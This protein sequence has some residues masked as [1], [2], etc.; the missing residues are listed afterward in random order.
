[1][2]LWQKMFI[3]FWEMVFLEF[4]HFYWKRRTFQLNWIMKW[5][6]VLHAELNLI[7]WEKD[8]FYTFYNPQ[9]FQQT[10]SPF[11]VIYFNSKLS[12]FNFMLIH[13]KSKRL[14]IGSDCHL[15]KKRTSSTLLFGVDCFRIWSK[16][17]LTKMK[18]RLLHD[19]YSIWFN[20]T[21]F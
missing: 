1:M 15:L 5:K 3:I 21:A 8:W 11:P 13:R 18:N 12:Y 4:G 20:L 10:I 14:T 2:L 7:A 17:L 16:H 19:Y 6:L 9:I